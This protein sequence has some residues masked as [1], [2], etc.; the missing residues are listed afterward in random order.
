[1]KRLRWTAR[2]SMLLP[3]VMFGL[4]ACAAR[5]DFFVGSTPGAQFIGVTPV[6]QVLH[7]DNSGNFLGIFIAP[8]NNLAT[9]RGLAF[10]PDGQLY[11]SSA[12][13]DS[14]LR[15]DGTSGAFIDA[16]VPKGSGGLKS[17]EVLIF[18]NDGFLYVSNFGTNPP[19]N[20]LDGKVTRYNATTGEFHGVFAQASDIRGNA[21]GMAFGPNG[22]LFVSVLNRNSPDVPGVLRFDGM[23]GN[24][25]GQFTQGGSLALPRGMTFGPDGNLY[26]ADI[27]PNSSIADSRVA[28]FDGTTGQYLDDYIPFGSGLMT[29]RGVGFGPDGR[30][31]VSTIYNPNQPYFNLIWAFDG[32]TLSNFIDGNAD[33]S[34]LT[35]PTYFVFQ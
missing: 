35:F 13:S 34:Q 30:L 32:T 20:T 24:L 31:Y 15:Y 33:S 7:Y 22:D 5:A 17:P 8:G 21:D 10:G 25:I 12:G 4:S 29:A 3:M 28:R 11:V 16:F 19:P 23:T 14:I 27:D 26:V 2:V 9:P 6:P 18:Q 1:M